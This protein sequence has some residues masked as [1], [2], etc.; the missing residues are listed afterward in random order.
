[1]LRRGLSRKFAIRLE[2]INCAQSREK[3]RSSDRFLYTDTIELSI[4][5]LPASRGTC[6]KSRRAMGEKL[7]VR[8][9]PNLCKLTVIV[10]LSV[11]LRNNMI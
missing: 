5:L 1:M 6:G 11:L 7:R 2:S 9:N 8:F 4:Q 10:V 3:A